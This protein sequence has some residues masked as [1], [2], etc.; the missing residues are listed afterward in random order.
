M[1]ANDEVHSIEHLSTR[2]CW[3]AL[4]SA[5]IGRLAVI[6]DDHPEIFP[7]TYVVDH[8]TVVFRSAEGSK[9]DGVRSGYP[10]AFEVDGYDRSTSKAW[11]AVIKG[12][13]EKHQDID[14]A[15][16]GA[17]LPLFPWQ[18]GEKNHFVR[19]VPDQISGRRFPVQPSARRRPGIG[20]ELDIE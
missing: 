16:A 3:D 1:D 4:R 14:E 15:A 5:D 12:T 7:L 19:I 10:L 8:G 13:A 17:M 2:E 11:S 9:L 20:E 18:P 6:I